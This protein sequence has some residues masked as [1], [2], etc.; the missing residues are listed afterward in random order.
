MR[1]FL[2]FLSSI[3]AYEM[4]DN[5][6]I[7]FE[8][9]QS[10]GTTNV[11]KLRINASNDYYFNLPAR[12][13]Y[14][15]ST[16][17]TV[18]CSGGKT[19]RSIRAKMVNGT[20]YVERNGEWI[21]T[22]T[23]SMSPLLLYNP[24]SLG[25][26]LIKSGNSECEMREGGNVLDCRLD[27]GILRSL[28]S[29]YLGLPGNVNVKWMTGSLV[30]R[31]SKAGLSGDLTYKFDVSYTLGSGVNVEQKGTGMEEFLIIVR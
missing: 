14:Q 28:V 12:I 25:I 5:T 1:R 22:E 11:C 31:R 15:N 16:Y 9:I 29:Y 21:N 26:E 8:I 20:V 4:Q 2:S 6:T 19:V 3:T 23:S 10:N 18:S 24:V 17:V 30:L 13:V 7:S 27:E